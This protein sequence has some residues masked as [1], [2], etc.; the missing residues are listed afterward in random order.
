MKDWLGQ[1]SMGDVHYSEKAE[2]FDRDKPAFQAL[3]RTFL[4][5]SYLS[6]S[7]QTSRACF[8]PSLSIWAGSPFIKKK[9]C[10][11]KTIK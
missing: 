4:P 3:P 6:A 7:W 9:Q 8:L 5:T 11:I 10:M 1:S 2:T